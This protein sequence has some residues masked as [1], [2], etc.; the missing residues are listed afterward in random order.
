MKLKDI[1]DARI[2][3]VQ[4][5]G[6]TDD[7]GTLTGVDEKT[8]TRFSKRLYGINVNRDKRKAT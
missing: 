1:E 4:K 3:L 8:Y 5:Y 2:K 6:K 7:K